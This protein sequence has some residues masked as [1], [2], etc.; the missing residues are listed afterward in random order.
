MFN[1]GMQLISATV[2]VKAEGTRKMKDFIT[3]LYP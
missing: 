1:K 2:T 3:I